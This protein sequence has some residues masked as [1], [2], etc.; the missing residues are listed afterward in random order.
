MNKDAQGQDLWGGHFSAGPDQLMKEIN[1][2]ILFDKRLAVHDCEG[3]LAHATMLCEKGIISKADL[4]AIEEGL[5]IILEEIEQESFSFSVDLEDIHLNIEAKLTERKGEA[6][7]RLHT[8]RSRNDQVATDFRLWIRDACDR[9]DALLQ[10]F[11]AVLIENAEAHADSVMPGFTHLQAAQPV[12]LGHHLL[13]YVEMF[14][15]DRDRFQ[16]ARRRMNECPLGAAALAGTSFP[17]DR[18]MTAEALGFDRPSANSIDAV[19][20]RDFVVDYLSA[21]SL[22]AIHLSRLAEELVLWSTP[23]F[24]FVRMSER[25]SSG[26]S[27]MPQK[28]NPDAAE[29]LRGK[30]GRILGAMHALMVMLKG[31]PLAYSKDMQEDKEPLFDAADSLELCLKV[32]GTMLSTLTFRTEAMRAS[33]LLGYLTATDL[34]DWCVRVLNV[35]FRDA[36]GIAARAV[37]AAEDAGVMLSELSLE[38]LQKVDSRI[39]ADALGFLDIDSSVQSRKSF[40]GTAPERVKEAVASARQRFLDQG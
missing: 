5:A 30:S 35:P 8:G 27:I 19:S 20:D 38:D 13:A 40:G 6:G 17:I 14:G 16:S 2:S 24:G 15:R 29:L 32:A 3:S 21:A 18:V 9:A 25:F 1:A 31:L 10:A 34:A 33:A 26:S 11:Q 37:K 23:Q 36:H 12:T 39:T 4:E 28:R 22:T 7:R